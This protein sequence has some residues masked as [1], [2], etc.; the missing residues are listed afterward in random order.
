MP[1]VVFLCDLESPAALSHDFLS[2]KVK[3]VSVVVTPF[4][5]VIHVNS[6]CME[7]LPCGR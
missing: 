2:A 5:E 3:Y 7:Q 1:T 6:V 4:Y